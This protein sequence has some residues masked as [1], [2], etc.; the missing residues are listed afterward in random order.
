MLLWKGNSCLFIGSDKLPASGARRI[1]VLPAQPWLRGMQAVAGSTRGVRRGTQG[2]IAVREQG[3]AEQTKQFPFGC[4]QEK[5]EGKPRESRQPAACALRAYAGWVH[6]AQSM[7]RHAGRLSQPVPACTGR[8]H[9]PVPPSLPAQPRA[10]AGVPG[11]QHRRQRSALGQAAGCRGER[12]HS[13]SRPLGERFGARPGHWCFP[14]VPGEARRSSYLQILRCHVSGCLEPS[15]ASLREGV[16]ADG[17][18]QP[19]LG[20]G[21]AVTGAGA[22]PGLT[23][24]Q[25]LCTKPGS[26]GQGRRGTAASGNWR[27]MQEP[28]T[29]PGDLTGILTSAAGRMVPRLSA[30]D[31]T[32]PGSS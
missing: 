27:C 7:T 9:P 11:D 2:P 4:L 10:A 26:Q 16:Q 6:G 8:L 22:A 21:G 24:C 13:C 32:D 29:A 31:Q 17:A 28:S 3:L 15:P 18:A 12:W 25:P 5:D 14:A 23:R 30:S 1:K 19:P 20:A